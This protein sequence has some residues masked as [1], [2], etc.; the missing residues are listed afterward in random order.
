MI[1]VATVLAVSNALP[2]T[3]TAQRVCPDP[4]ILAGVR[5]TPGDAS[6]NVTFLAAE[7]IVGDVAVRLGLR[8]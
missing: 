6:R 5:P 3:P 4:A 1:A 8:P 2:I 7:R